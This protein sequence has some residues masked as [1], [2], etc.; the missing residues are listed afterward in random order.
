MNEIYYKQKASKLDK[1]G[2][3]P[4]FLEFNHDAQTLV[5]ATGEKCKLSEWDADKQKFRRSMA[6]YQQANEGL[7][8]LAD[9]LRLAYRQ[10]VNAGEPVTNDIL[11]AAISRKQP[12]PVV[13]GLVP[14]FA[15]F[16]TIRKSQ[17]YKEG[18]LVAMKTTLARLQWF[19]ATGVK[20]TITGYTGDVHNKLLEY[21][22]SRGLQ[23]PS[24]ANTCKHLITFFKYCVD[25]LKLQLHP[26]HAKIT[27]ETF[28]SDRIYL[29]ERDLTK[30]ETVALPPH[31]DRVRDA[32]LFQCYTSLRYTDL[33]RLRSHH[34][35]QRDGYKVICFIPDKSVSRKSIKIKRLEIPLLDGALRVLA[36]YPDD[37]TD[38]TYRLLPVLSNQKY[39]D[40]IKDVARLA[41]LLE[42]MEKIGYDQGVPRIETLPKWQLVTTHV[43]RHTYATLSLARGVPVE[44]IQ[45]VLGHEKISTTMIYA[46]VADEYKNQS[47]LQAWAVTGKLQTE[48][49]LSAEP[50]GTD[51]V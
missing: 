25:P 31:L 2:R 8:V 41:G 19:E 43:A 50:T 22:T 45:K 34:V 51:I 32:F 23:P 47:I 10:L 40:Y 1:S 27:K 18:A 13:V 11:R 12:V 39:N 15:E 29:N 26:H 35:E 36:R 16:I 46:K 6:G 44:V 28:A 30:L 9:R 38:S 4:I 48:K 7:S 24:I 21:L 20:L 5:Y 14:L 42:D 37:G 33:W 3:A 17:G 49:S